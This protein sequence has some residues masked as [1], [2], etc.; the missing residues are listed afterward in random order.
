[1]TDTAMKKRIQVNDEVEQIASALEEDIIF[2]RIGPGARLIEDELI[3]RF[4][5]KRYA[6]REVLRRL[7]GIG[8]VSRSPNKGASVR[9]YSRKELEDIYAV[10]QILTREAIELISFPVD[11]HGLANLQSIQDRYA[12]SSEAGDLMAINRFNH[13]FHSAL[14]AFCANGQLAG[15]IDHYA[16]LTQTFRAISIPSPELRVR[17]LAEHQAMIDC[18]HTGERERLA[19]LCVEHMIPA[20][21]MFFRSRGWLI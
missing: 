13:D 11:P 2:G 21:D 6:V 10:R 20:R 5:T 4:N 16:W 9:N 17:A 18:L 1:M 14:Y 12:K 19:R 15:L 8:I 7:E 3:A